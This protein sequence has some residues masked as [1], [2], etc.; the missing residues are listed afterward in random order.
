[1]NWES[2]LLMRSEIGLLAIILL[3]VIFEI[4]SNKKQK[5]GIIPFALILANY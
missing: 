3:L 2:L 5:A 4:F 1:M